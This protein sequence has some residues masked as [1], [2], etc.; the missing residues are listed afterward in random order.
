MLQSKICR[1][2]KGT[3]QGHDILSPD[4]A[5][6]LASGNG[7]ACDGDDVHCSQTVHENKSDKKYL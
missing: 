3:L 2:K 4:P 5:F 6:M 7:K 1:V